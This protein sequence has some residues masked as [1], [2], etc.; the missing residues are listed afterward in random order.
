MAA[1]LQVKRLDSVQRGYLREIDMTD[2]EAFVVHN[3]APPSLRR[4]IGLL[5][6]LHKRVLGKCHPGL[7]HILPFAQGLDANYHSKALHPFEEKQDFQ[8]RL[9]RHSLFA[10]ILVYIRLSQGLVDLPSVKNFQSK[11]TVLAKFRSQTGEEGW[12]RSFQDCDEVAMM[13]YPIN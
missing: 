12:R 10:Y 5:G 6:L 11:L 3:F 9:Y 2:T 4:C 13:I 7:N 1:G 8:A